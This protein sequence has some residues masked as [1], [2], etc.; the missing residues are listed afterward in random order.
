VPNIPF[1]DLPWRSWSPTYSVHV[2]RCDE[3]ANWSREALVFF[4]GGKGDQ[5]LL[6]VFFTAAADVFVKVAKRRTLRDLKLAAD[7][8]PYNFSLF[9]N[10]FN[11]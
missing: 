7:A 9:L 10:L 11:T 6:P 3:V 8:M 5:I 1:I 2:T 4:C